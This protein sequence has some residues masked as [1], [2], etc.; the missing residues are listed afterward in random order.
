VYSESYVAPMKT[1]QRGAI[2][3]ARVKLLAFRQLETWDRTTVEMGFQNIWYSHPR[4]YGQG[5]RS[6]WV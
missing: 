6:W 4:K 5:S 3:V 2:Y 1:S